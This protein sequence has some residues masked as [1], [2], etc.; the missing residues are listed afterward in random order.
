M[1]IRKVGI[2][3]IKSEGCN[4]I[5]CFTSKNIFLINLYFCFHVYDRIPGK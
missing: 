1:C 5:H 2:I 4:A 3:E